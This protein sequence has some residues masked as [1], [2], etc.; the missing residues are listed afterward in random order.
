MESAKVCPVVEEIATDPSAPAPST[1]RAR[2]V[3][4]AS[5]AAGTVVQALF[6]DTG[7][8]L[9]WFLAIA[10]AVVASFVLF[11]ERPIRGPAMV[12]AVSSIALAAAPV[13]RA[14][15]FNQV[16]AVPLSFVAAALVP[17][18]LRSRA[19]FGDLPMFVRELDRTFLGSLGAIRSTVQLP[20]DAFEGHGKQ[21]FGSVARGCAI[22]LPIAGL[23]AVL[24]GAD[25][26]FSALVERS[27]GQSVEWVYFAG[28][29]IATACAI[30]I[31]YA[32]NA[33]D[34][35]LAVEGPSSPYRVSARAA[36]A[37][38]GPV[39]P[40]TWSL[41]I[42]QVV[43]VFVV[44]VVA[45]ARDL[46][47]GHDVVR[48]ADGPTYAS[49]LHAGFASLLVASVLS[50]GLVLAGH[51]FLS[52]PG[53]RTPA[54]GPV[55]RALECSLLLLSGVTVASCWQRLSVYVDAYGATEL[56]LG[57]AFVEIA[58]VIMLVLTATKS[59]ARS[60]QGYGGAALTSVCV[61]G[62]AAAMFNADGYIAHTNLERA[63]NG[64]GLD[65]RYLASLSPDACAAL[66]HPLVRGDATLRRPLERRFEA[67]FAGRDVRS[68]RGVLPRASCPRDSGR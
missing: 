9:N 48:A 5:L 14:G 6:W 28:A 22:G 26:K 61:L 18:L 19:G 24:L 37:L 25:P 46:F 1:R 50:I 47:G 36:E 33:R 62:T 56:R 7:V 3:L 38:R 52:P 63:A 53:A 58:V 65:E 30:A 15:A 55:L 27:F 31:G 43:A 35:K 4:A 51:A 59:I 44:F 2:R 12:A 29:S 32:M 45:N 20:K 11:T 23:F 68:M 64:K 8:G 13:L 39:K 54:G 17:V 34:K 66:S 57:V 41:I 60:W 10:G 49:Y 40:L 42:A 21:T 16:V 67:Y